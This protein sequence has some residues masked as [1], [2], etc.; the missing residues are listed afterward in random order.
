MAFIESPRFPEEISY[1][2]S[3]GPEFSTSIATS[4][5]GFE[6]RNRNRSRGLCVGECSHALKTKAQLDELLTFFRSM[7][8][9]FHSFRF[10][11]WA[12]YQC[13]AAQSKMTLISTGVYQMYKVYEAAIGFSEDR[14]IS[15][16]VT[17]TVTIFRT[18]S[19]VTTNITGSSSINFTTGAVTVTGHVAGDVYTWSGEFDVPCRFDTDRM[20]INIE[21]PTGYDWNQI[22]IK[23]IAL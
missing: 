11:D 2:V 21:N 3:F 5:S 20:S 18:R 13:T 19:A 4:Q 15:K 14:K 17:G 23:E 6:V 8:G 1:G 12:D 16:P 22:P 10:K 9:R 7:G